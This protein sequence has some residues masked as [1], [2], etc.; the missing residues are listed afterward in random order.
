[1]WSKPGIQPEQTN[2]SQQ[3][4]LI[5]EPGHDLQAALARRCRGAGAT[6]ADR[7]IK[8]RGTQCD[9][10][11]MRHMIHFTDKGDSGKADGPRPLGRGGF[12]QRR[13]PP[14]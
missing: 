8:A 14:G 10:A 4:F 6:F 7:D 9:D 13:K 12:H 3:N 11:L 5:R 2:R 1:V